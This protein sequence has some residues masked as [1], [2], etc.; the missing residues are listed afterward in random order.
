MSY[1]DERTPFERLLDRAGWIILTL[2]ALYITGHL[3]WAWLR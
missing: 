2:A 3:I 1:K